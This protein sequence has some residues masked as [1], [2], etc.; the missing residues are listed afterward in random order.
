MAY[1]SQLNAIAPFEMQP[2]S[3]V[4]V[5][6]WYFGIPSERIPLQV[7]AAAPGLFTR[8]GS[9]SGPA[10]VVN[11]D[12]SVNSPSPPGS[13][14]ALFGTGLARWRAPWMERWRTRHRT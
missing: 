4:D 5:Q 2:R 8:G 10:A 7:A 9:G 1:G 3:T 11:Q 14:I 13:V 12:G 6:V